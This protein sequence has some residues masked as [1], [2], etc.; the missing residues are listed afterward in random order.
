MF[1]AL[2]TADLLQS[3]QVAGAARLA[4][5]RLRVFSSA[6]A[7]CAALSEAALPEEGARLVIVDLALPGLDIR[8]LVERLQTLA[9]GKPRMLAFGPHVHTERLAA[10]REAGC[11]QVISRG[12]FHSQM[13]ELLA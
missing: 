11:D 6:D 12:Q 4:N 3:S 10:A 9:A 2:L 7:L 5:A 8:A 13:D 1:V